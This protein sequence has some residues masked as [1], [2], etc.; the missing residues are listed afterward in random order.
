MCHVG[1]NHHNHDNGNSGDDDD[2]GVVD[3]NYRDHINF[4]LLFHHRDTH[5]HIENAHCA[6]FADNRFPQHKCFQVEAFNLTRNQI[7][8][9]LLLCE[10]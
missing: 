6:F 9:G 8:C 10:N 4:V 3:N 7:K 2:D 1:I 5:S